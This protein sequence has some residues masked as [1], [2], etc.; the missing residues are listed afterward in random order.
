MRK[1]TRRTYRAVADINIA[2][3]VDV[4]LVLL[5][6]FMISAPLL[7]SGIEV[8]LPKTK[9][10]P[11][12]EQHEGIVITLDKKGGLYIN[13]V[14]TRLDNF[15]SNLTKAMK[16]KNTTSVYLRSDSSV[17]YGTAIEVIGRMKQM[18]IDQIALVTALQEK[19]LEKTSKKP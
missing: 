9:A 2:N 19:G 15:E 10:A 16:A 7:Q 6:I 4:C 1:P 8:N 13:D 3:L 5:I 14:W 12:E 17:A 18:G 11:P